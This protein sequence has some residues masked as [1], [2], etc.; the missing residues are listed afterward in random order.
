MSADQAT[1]PHPQTTPKIS[2][3]L[4]TGGCGFIGAA[5]TRRLTSEGVAVRI[6]DNL[7]VGQ[8]D[9]VG[10]PVRVADNADGGAALN[11]A[12]NAVDILPGEITDPATAEAAAD[13]AEAIVHLAANTGV[14][15]SI[16]EPRI[17]CLSNVVGTL[18][19]LEAARASGVK[20]FVFASSGAPA[21]EVE[22][23]IHEN[24]VP[25]PVSPYGASKLAGE[26]YCGAY[27]RSFGIETVALRFGNVFGP[28]S[29][30]KTSVVAK[31]CTHAMAGEPLEIFGTGRQ[32][33]DFIFIDDL[34]HAVERGLVAEDVG[35]EVFQIA[36]SRETTVEE[37]AAMIQTACREAGVAVPEV[38]KS[39]ARHGDVL[40]NFSDTSK[41]ARVLGWQAQHSLAEGIAT[42]LNYFV[43]AQPGP[44]AP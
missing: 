39:P 1:T 37:I 2:R 44:S 23:P 17:D 29:V 28:G 32:T 9:D 38:I 41:A 27:W 3:V 12:G 42:T 31:F 4:I 14:P 24:I 40:R 8:P 5:L 35:G 26:A 34:I 33:R 20:R 6:L 19:M 36:T 13:G 30:R 10:L 43:S 16:A 11:W 15:K 7:S 21:G 18:T 22:P 25:R